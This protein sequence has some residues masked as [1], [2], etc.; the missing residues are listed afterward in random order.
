MTHFR[1]FSETSINAD[2]NERDKH[3]KDFSIFFYLSY[4]NRVKDAHHVQV[5]DVK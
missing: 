5:E 3:D 4:E 2:V 1:D